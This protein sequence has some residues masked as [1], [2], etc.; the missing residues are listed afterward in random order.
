MNEEQVSQKIKE[1]LL[2][3]LNSSF[4]TLDK[5]C[6]VRYSA[7]CMMEDYINARDAIE[8]GISLSEGKNL[9]VEKI[10]CLIE[11]AMQEIQYE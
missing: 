3:M 6:L 5:E 7:C 9:L 4:Q 8:K 10:N 11:I 2:F 1:K